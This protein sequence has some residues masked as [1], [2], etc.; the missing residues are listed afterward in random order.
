MGFQI[1][2]NEISYLR[3]GETV[4]LSACGKNSIRFQASPNGRIENQDWTLMPRKAMASAWLENDFAVLENG[5]M[6]AELYKDGRAVYYCRD[7]KILA[8]KP[9]LAFGQGIR[10]YRSKA[11]GQWSARVTFEPNEKEHF[12]G[13][14]HESTG[15]FDLKGCTIDLRHVNAKCAI[16]FVYSSLGYGFLWNMPSTG[17]CE[18]ANNRTRWTSDSTKQIDYVVIGGMPRQVSETLADLTGHAPEMP[19]WATGFWQS[20]L[21]YETKEEVLRVAGRYKEMGI[22]LSVIVIDYFHWTEQGDYKFDP[23]YWRDPKEMADKLHEM[24]VKLMVS[25]WPTINEKSENYQEMLDGNM[26]IR[27]AAGSNRVFDFYGQQ[28]EIDPTNPQTRRFVWD[29]LKKNYIDN[30]VDCLWFD[31][32]EPEIHPEQFDNLILSMGRGDEVGLLYPYYYA[33][34]VYDGMKEIGR[35]DIV[36]LSRCA[37]LGAQKFGTLVWSGDIPSTFESLSA[38]VK[39]GLNMAMCG[40]PWWNTDIG[41]FYGG[42][43]ESAY[44]R[45]LIVRWFQYG[46]FCPVTRLHGSRKGQDRT[47]GIIEPTGGD[48]ELWSFGEE[49]FE[50]LKELVMLRERLRPYVETHMK[51]ASQK[52]TPMMR[53]IFYDY[54]DDEQCYTLGEQYLFGDDILFAPITEQ[55]QTKK[56]VY[57]PQGRWVLTKDAQTYL[58]GRWYTIEAAL[59]EFIAFVKEGAEVIN[60]FHSDMQ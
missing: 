58:G 5:S 34:L 2:N 7:K 3:N 29:K 10:N 50:I 32:A 9:E 55:G 47:R 35:D 59:N 16:P 56:E 48:N 41:G 22:P 17:R 40:I 30:G 20:R 26:L 45:E 25:M 31:E 43:T 28:A 46:V 49:A 54:P 60:C 38:Q 42:D 36:T 18:L 21:R 44:F 52:G 4:R 11:S 33:K 53:P 39:S 24:G 37:Y 1:Q 51:T 6:R 19:Y 13:L 27:T 57:L 8:E 15:C 14:G 12:Y 23:K